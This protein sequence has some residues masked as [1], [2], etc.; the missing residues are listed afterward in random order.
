[1]VF[2]PLAGSLAETVTFGCSKSNV[3]RLEGLEFCMMT[4]SSGDNGR[5][6]ALHDE[7]IYKTDLQIHAWNKFTIS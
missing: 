2:I 6:T 4:S 3:L 1:L 5:A 7:S